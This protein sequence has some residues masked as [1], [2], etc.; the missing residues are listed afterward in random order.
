MDSQYFD[1]LLRGKNINFLIGAGASVPIFPTLRL[2]DV[3]SLEDILSD[4]NLNEFARYYV[5]AYYFEHWIK[6]MS[7]PNKTREIDN[8]KKKNQVKENY[9]KFVELICEFLYSESNEKPKRV[10][11]FTTN[12][13]L[14]FENTFDSILEKIP[15]VFFNDGSRGFSKK[16]IDNNNFYLNVSHSGYNDN[17][18]REVPTINLYKMHGSLSWEVDNSRIK[19]TNSCESVKEVSSELKNISYIQGDVEYEFENLLNNKSLEK[20]VE[21]INKFIDEHFEIH[22]LLKAFY[23]KYIMIPIINPNKYK[24]SKTVSEQHYYQLIRDFSYE[25]EKEEAILIVFGFSFADEHIRDI[26][27]RSLL[28]PQLQ[29]IIISYSEGDQ[30][31]MKKYFEMYNNVIFLPGKWDYN[32]NGECLNP[33][34]FNYLLRLMGDNNA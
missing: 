14:M 4:E 17:Y 24:F 11:L 5:L 34:D 7:M 10:N 15:L 28:N 25:L 1:E 9:Y 18:K 31:L 3:F 23:D 16:Y 2:N 32:S 33:G 29:V 8:D 19:V 12:Y 13:D 26:F 27:E 30:N 6:I 20:T 22:Q 21:N